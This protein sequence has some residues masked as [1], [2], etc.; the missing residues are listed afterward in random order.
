MT[1]TL[2]RNNDF[3]KELIETESQLTQQ[4]LRVLRGRYSQEKDQW[5][6]MYKNKEEEIQSLRSKLSDTEERIRRIREDYGEEKLEEAE[7]LK[8]SVKSIYERKQIEIDKWN[9]IED[10]VKTYKRTIEELQAH[11]LDEQ[12][13]LVKA[14]EKHIAEEQSMRETILKYEEKLLGLRE[15]LLRKEDEWA[16]TKALLDSEVLHLKEKI[17]NFEQIVKNEKDIHFKL[18]SEKE[19]NSGKLQ[20]AVQELSV[21]FTEE[22]RAND[23]LKS[24]LQEKEK[25]ISV[26]ELDN[27]K[28]FDEISSER[29]K[30]QETYNKEQQEWEK[31]KHGLMEKE[32]SLKMETEEQ[33]SRVNAMLTILENQLSSER[34][35][36]ESLRNA[37]DEKETRAKMLIMELDELQK[38]TA[39]QKEQLE[40]QLKS[41][42]DL[43]GKEKQE[44]MT[45]YHVYKTAKEAETDRLNMEVSELRASVNEENRLY[46]IEK[47]EKELLKRETANLRDDYDK[48]AARLEAERAEWKRRKTEEELRS[49]GRVDEIQARLDEMRKAREEEIKLLNEEINTLNGQFNELRVIYQQTKAENYQ[50]N[51]RVRELEAEVQKILE[52]SDVER[53]EWQSMLSAQQKN[54]ENQKSELAG[55]NHALL[56]ERDR[57]IKKIEKALDDVTIKLVSSEREIQ[58]KDREIAELLAKARD[59]GR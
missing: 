24:I 35:G 42:E 13:R 47:D 51:A 45:Q 50:Q 21:K 9:A 30:W 19:E 2:E 6:K 33:V 41:Q 54:W 18:M 1:E 27:K 49:E 43:H 36:N 29:A 28:I 46:R 38:I 40:R 7:K 23:R 15:A 32:Q 55:R 14:R 12:N 22:L 17:Q 20:S 25:L 11:L 58:R 4:A 44:I 10:K 39:D 37:L 34:A 31:Y 3:L 56:S 16:K 57:E 59:S 26:L 8:L 48:I 5:S 52:H 53:R